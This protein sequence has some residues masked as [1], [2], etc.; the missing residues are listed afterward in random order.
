M[1]LFFNEL[2]NKIT[3]PDEHW[4]Q[5]SA[6]KKW[7]PAVTKI[8]DAY[9]KGIGYQLYLQQVGMNAGE[10]LRKAGEIG[11]QV[12]ALI[13]SWAKLPKDYVISYLD[14]TGKEK[15]PFEVWELFCRAMN[16]FEV[17]KPEIIV[18]EFSFANDSLGYGGTIDMICKIDGKIF[19]IDYKSGNYIYE[20]HKLQVA[21]YAKAWNLLNPDL[22]I[23]FAGILHLKSDTRTVNYDKMQGIGW[24][25]IYTDLYEI[26]FQDFEHTHKIWLREHSDDKPKIKEFP[27]S[28]KK[29]S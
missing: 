13:D 20:S 5:S 1:N 29:L 17:Y 24:K 26:D 6:T 28:F 14:E 19:L 12:H 4:Y 2:E 7:L 25:L 10:I 8:L 15:Y 11:S 18:H 21:A 22:K 16:F 23:D 27:L 9:P 3:I